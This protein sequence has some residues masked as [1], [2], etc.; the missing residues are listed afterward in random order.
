MAEATR[1]IGGWGNA[2]NGVKCSPNVPTEEV[3]TVPHRE[4]VDG[5]VS[6]TKPL[7][8]RGQVIDG[9]RIEFSGGEAVKASAK[10]GEEIL[11]KLL[12]TDDG[13]RR[14][15]EVALVPAGSPI[16]K[17]GVLFFNTLYDENAA[18][19]IALGRAIDACFTNNASLSEEER[20]ALGGNES[21]V[22]VD[23]M[24]GS[25]HI[26][27]DGKRADG[28]SIPLLRKGEWAQSI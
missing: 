17:S 4:R 2:T 22:H 1:W 26:D 16:S 10:A 21:I 28:S 11:L 5:F 25:E 8:L 24:I 18:C 15:G 12:Q 19:H 9:I 6:S 7:S 20:R 23:W 14:L 27:L 13:A 3:F